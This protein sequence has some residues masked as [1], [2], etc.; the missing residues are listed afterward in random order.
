MIALIISFGENGRGSVR[1]AVICHC[2]NKWVGVF[3][4]ISL[5]TESHNG[6]SVSA[7]DASDI[8]KLFVFLVY[9]FI[10]CTIDN[11]FIESK[12]RLEKNTWGKFLVIL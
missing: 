5:I 6:V 8:G 12:T 3:V 4:I 9:T 2:R 1:G 11:T 10:T 7:S